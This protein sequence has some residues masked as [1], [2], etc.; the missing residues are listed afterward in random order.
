MW[1]HPQI[2]DPEVNIPGYYLLRSDCA[3]IM[4]GSICVYVKSNIAAVSMLAYSN[5]V[6]EALVTKIKSLNLILFIVYRHPGASPEEFLD[7][8]DCVS[9]DIDIIKANNNK[10]GNILGLGDFNLPGMDWPNTTVKTL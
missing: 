8:M 7:A 4:H 10:Y 2:L 9:T 1:L 6:V 3:A 5:G